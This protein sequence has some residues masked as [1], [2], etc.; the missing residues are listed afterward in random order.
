MVFQK[1]KIS[2]TTKFLTMI[3]NE[4]SSVC[5]LHIKRAATWWPPTLCGC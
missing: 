3:N 4:A 2:I 1:E 5:I